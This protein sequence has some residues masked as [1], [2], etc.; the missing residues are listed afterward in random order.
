MMPGVSFSEDDFRFLTQGLSGVVKSEETI[1]LAPDIMNKLR[2]TDAG[3][4]MMQAEQVSRLCDFV[5]EITTAPNT[6]FLPFKVSHN[7][8]SLSD[9]YKMIL[10][11]S[12]VMHSAL[13]EDTEQ[14]IIKFR[15]LLQTTIKKKDLVSGQDK[16]VTAPSPLAMAYNERMANYINAALEYNQHRVDVIAGP[17]PKAVQFWAINADLLRAKVRAAMDDWIINGYKNDFEQIVGYIDQVQARDVSVLKREY[18]DDLARAA[19][20]GLSSGADFF[21]TALVP[22]DLSQSSGWSKFTFDARELR[23]YS[24]A[25][26]SGSGWSASAIAN[27][28]GIGASGGAAH[29]EQKQPY[30]GKLDLNYFKLRF[31]ICKALIIRPWFKEHFIVSKFWRFDESNPAVKEFNGIVSDGGKPPTGLIPAYPTAAIF[32]RDVRLD[33]GENTSFSDYYNRQSTSNE[34]GGLNISLGPFSLGGKA[35]HWSNDGYS[36]QTYGAHLTEHGISAPGVQLIG[37]QCHMFDNKCPDPDPSAVTH[38]VDSQELRKV[39]CWAHG[40]DSVCDHQRDGPGTVAS[41][42]G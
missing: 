5:P 30:D 3:R 19:L 42:C 34:G 26:V 41:D 33:F 24:N 2:A 21:Y 8:G 7:H 1:N 40:S 22:G 20:R 28:L 25:S 9:R 12:Q 6:A 27:Y 13:S 11:M 35:K 14:R 32:V 23:K 16:D 4:M 29:S 31:S 18:E 36:K 10:T 15:N 38:S 17:D 39:R 37:F